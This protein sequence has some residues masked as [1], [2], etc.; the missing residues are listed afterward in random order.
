MER[1]E[2]VPLNTYSDLLQS[3]CIQL[4]YELLDMP[5]RIHGA[6]LEVKQSHYILCIL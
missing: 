2:C 5:S 4:N 6:R 1:M 3:Q